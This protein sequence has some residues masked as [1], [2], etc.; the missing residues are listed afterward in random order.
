MAN[1]VE[2]RD[3]SMSF[4]TNQV[5]RGVNLTIESGKVTALLG[6]NGAGKS[7]LIKIL[8]GLYPNHGGTVTVNGDPAILSY[9]REAKR[10][11]IQT[12]HQRIDE[13]VVPGLSVAEN[14]LFEKI[15]SRDSGRVGSLRSLL[16]EAREVAASLGLDWS[17]RFLRKDV[18]ELDIADQQLLTLARAVHDKPKLLV[19][20]EPTSALSTKEVDDLMAVIRQMRDS[21]VGILY[22]SHRLGEIDMIADEL[23][24]LR[25]GVIRG[26]Q[27]KPFDWNEAL[28]L[29]L[30]EETR[31]DIEQKLDLRGGDE[32]LHLSGVQ[33]FPRSQ[34]FDLG[35]RSGEVTGVIGLLGSGKTEIAETLYGARTNV[36]D[37]M[38]LDGQEFRPRHPATAI[39]NGVYLVPE[40][41]AKESMFSEWSIA[42]TVALP[43][44]HLASRGLVVQPQREREMGQGV[45]DE[46]SVVAQSP[47]QPVDALSGGNQ[48]KVIVGRWLQRDPRLLILDEPF[49]G[50]DIGARRTIALK[51]S[52]L[53][54]SGKAVIVLTSEVDELLEVADRVIVLVDGV[55]VLDTYLSETS[56]EDIVQSMSQVGQE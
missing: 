47:D 2:M 56:R 26:E 27:S 31:E 4:G 41:R 5:L 30:G 51:A 12:V 55:P 49:R 52:A 29:M 39:K 33:L 15:S 10:Q 43:F 14:L 17:N 32:I 40:D 23:V 45:I 34:K 9:P 36:A 16:P 46:F 54:E 44:L 25:D 20:D 3:I 24:V 13:A 21:G 35:I 42:K 19:L 28:T 6:A 7:T 48:Q 22:V 8:S 37:L 18:Y 11:G 38:T 50:V 53:A 1:S